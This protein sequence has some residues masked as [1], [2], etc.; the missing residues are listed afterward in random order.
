M[1]PSR[2]RMVVFS[3]VKRRK[4]TAMG[5]IGAR[6]RRTR[7]SSRKIGTKSTA[8]KMEGSTKECRDEC[9]QH[10]QASVQ[11]LMFFAK[12]VKAKMQILRIT[13]TEYILCLISVL[14]GPGLARPCG[15][16]SILSAREANVWLGRPGLHRSQWLLC[17]RGQR[18]VRRRGRA[19][20]PATSGSRRGA[21]STICECQ[22]GGRNR[23]RG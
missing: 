18:R 23:R 12:I 20:C 13:M 4:R 11:S 16:R 10:L 19:K 2:R 8:T 22:R 14:R 21:A 15:G 1:L 6:G 5:G 9:T 3:E 17:G 7:Y